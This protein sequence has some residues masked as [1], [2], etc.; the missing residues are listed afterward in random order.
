MHV[1]NNMK[2]TYYIIQD[3]LKVFSMFNI[4]IWYD[5]DKDKDNVPDNLQ[6][7]CTKCNKIVGY[8]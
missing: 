3:L 7:K 5:K 2:E 6:I 1:S 8:E 4:R